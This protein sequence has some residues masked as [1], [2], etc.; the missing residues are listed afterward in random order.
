MI[1]VF[2]GVPDHIVIQYACNLSISPST[3]LFDVSGGE[4]VLQI[5]TSDGC[6]WQVVTN[7]PWIRFSNNINSGSG[8]ASVVFSVP[9]NADGAPA[10]DGNIS[11]RQGDYGYGLHVIQNGC[12]YTIGSPDYEFFEY[13]GGQ[14]RF[15]VYT[16]DTSC[17]YSLE[18]DASWIH[19]S[20]LPSLPSVTRRPPDPVMHTDSSVRFRVDKN[21]TSS[22]REGR[23]F[24]KGSGL[25]DAESFKVIQDF[26]QQGGNKKPDE[27]E[28]E[29]ECTATIEPRSVSFLAF[30]SSSIFNVSFEQNPGTCS[31]SPTAD[32]DWI[33][34]IS[35]SCN[36]IVM[37]YE[38]TN[39]Q[40][41]IFW[42]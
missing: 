35:P 11:V 22:I 10:R 8:S 31:W 14:S 2:D 29:P 6:D 34:I 26:L 41:K 28:P 20:R 9:D 38:S 27:K 1:N 7:Q 39:Y 12:T 16:P 18:T 37:F 13:N 3:K 40:P 17:S 25:D 23:I 32:R 36:C 33:N 30:A 21:E 5:S 42:W 15:N 24:V 4:G 19:L